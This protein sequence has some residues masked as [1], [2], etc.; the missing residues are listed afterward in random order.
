VTSNRFSPV[1]GWALAGALAFPALTLAL[2]YL[3]TRLLV[4]LALGAAGAGLAA[5][6]AL[7]AFGRRGS[8]RESARLWAT[9]Y[10]S[11]V[12]V[13][14]TW[15][16]FPDPI[17]DYTTIVTPDGSPGRGYNTAYDVLRVLVAIGVTLLVGGALDGA[18]RAAAGRRVREAGVSAAAWAVVF[19]PLPVLIVIAVYAAS[20]IGS[21]V[22]GGLGMSAP[23]FELGLVCAGSLLGAAVGGAAEGLVRRL[24]PPPM[25]WTEQRMFTP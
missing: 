2:G 15:L 20:I 4:A 16:Q 17:P 19:V 9:A 14:L 22:R 13:Y 6:A 8:A 12:L 5:G 10:V 3:E 1:W 21:A 18:S 11:G 23:A 25:P 24:A 7:A